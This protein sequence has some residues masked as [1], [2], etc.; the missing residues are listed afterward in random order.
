[1]GGHFL[2]RKY[3]P[4]LNEIKKKKNIVDPPFIESIS[5]YFSVK[6]MKLKRSVSII[7]IQPKY[8]QNFLMTTPNYVDQPDDYE[9]NQN[10]PENN[11]I[12]NNPKGFYEDASENIVFARSQNDM[13]VGQN[14]KNSSIKAYESPD[15]VQ[16]N[17]QNLINSF[18]KEEP[19]INIR[20]FQ[21]EEMK[22]VTIL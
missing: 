14:P 19:E 13:K 16:R 3:Y 21:E 11:I 20:D 9:N 6:N 15:F 22:N 18:K 10:I 8:P 2:N 1:M 7:K 5:K 17:S 12:N 4:L